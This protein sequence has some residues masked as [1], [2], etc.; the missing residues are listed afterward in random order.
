MDEAA[1]VE[2]LDSTLH[3]FFGVLVADAP[4]PSYFDAGPSFADSPHFIE[5]SQVHGA[6]AVVAE[7]T[8]ENHD[9]I[10]ITEQGQYIFERRLLQDTET[11]FDTGGFQFGRESG[12]VDF[13]LIMDDH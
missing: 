4:V 7:V 13:G 12:V 8:A 1:D 10:E 5:Q 9:V 2:D 11:G 3:E 6:A